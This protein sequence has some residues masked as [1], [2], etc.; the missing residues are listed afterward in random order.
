MNIKGNKKP[1][2]VIVNIIR[3]VFRKEKSIVFKGVCLIKLLYSTDKNNRMNTENININIGEQARPIK[4]SFLFKYGIPFIKGY[5]INLYTMEFDIVKLLKLDIQNKLRVNYSNKYNGRILYSAYDLNQGHNRN[6]RIIKEKG[7]SI[8]FRQTVKNSMYIT[9]REQNKYDYIQGK[10]KI[11]VAFMLSKFSF[12]RNLVLIFEKEC[13]KYEE[14]GSVLYENLIDEGYSNVF[15]IIDK[16][17]FQIKNIENKYRNNLVFKDSLKHIILF[18]KCKKFIGTETMGHAMQLRAANHLIVNKVQCKDI[19]Y[20][21]LQ[22]G[23]MYMVPL[24]S[25]L[26][27]GFKNQNIKIH[28]IVVSSE[29]EEKHFIEKGGFKKENIYITGLAKFDRSFKNKEADKIVIML[30]WRRWE[31]N[32]AR[33]DLQDTKYCKMLERM[34]LAIPKEYERQIVVLLH[35]LMKNSF[36]NDKCLLKKYMNFSDSYDEVLREC[37]LFITDYSSMA[38]DAFYRGSNVIFFWEEKDECMM[39]YGEDV[40]L[41]LNSENAFG[42]IC[43]DVSGL[44]QAVQKNYKQEHNKV[45][46]ENY[47]KIV[48]FDDGNNTKRIINKLIDDEIL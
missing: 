8:Y 43:F 22:H 34:V 16:N 19:I 44:K 46:E 48:Q 2:P 23:V 24:N 3:S 26:R 14:S 27:T 37:S 29:L 4:S 18:F 11:L 41:M 7:M 39:H 13:S 47:K 25:E 20:V 9:V 32:N 17:N 33:S 12:R 38:Y 31:A 30:T 28:R 6:S 5:R 45:Y 15:F 40:D 36:T 42:D 21:F 1:T 10:I 35:P